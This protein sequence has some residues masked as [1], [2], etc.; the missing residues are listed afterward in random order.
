MR[1]NLVLGLTI[2]F[3]EA[4]IMS[5][6]SSNTPTFGDDD[7]FGTTL[8]VGGNGPNNYTK[9]QDAIDNASNGDTVFV[10]DDSS[11]YY[12]N[13]I[14]DKSINLTGENKD[15]TVIDGSKWTSV[16]YVSAERVNITGFTI[17]N[18]GITYPAAAVNIESDSNRVF[19]NIFM[20]NFCSIRLRH[21][22]GNVIMRNKINSN[23]GKGVTLEYSTDNLIMDNIILKN[24][25][26][27]F[28]FHSDNNIISRNHLG[29][30]GSQ[31]GGLMTV[32]D[33]PNNTIVGNIFLHSLQGLNLE[34][35]N[36]TVV[37]NNSF[38]NNGFTVYNS[39]N[40]IVFNNTVNDKPLLY[41]E[42]VSGTDIVVKEV[43]QVVL[44]NC[45]SIVIQNQMLCN[46]EVGIE[47]WK[48][49]NCIILNNTVSS[50]NWHGIWVCHSNNNTI[51]TTTI[52][53]NNGDG[54]RIENSC[55]NTLLGN[56]ILGNGYG[57]WLKNSYGNIL[58][59]NNISGNNDDG[60][61]VYNCS[62]TIITR[63][64]IGFNHY[65]GIWLCS[66]SD[67]NNILENNIIRN[68]NDGI[69]ISYDSNDNFLYHNNFIN[70]TLKNACDEGINTWD[71]GYPS[72]G[73]Y[74][75][76]FDEPEE[77]AYD[78]YHGPNQD[79][80]GSDGIVDKGY[81]A[82]GGLN[83]YH[84][85]GG[86]N[87]DTYPLIHP[88]GVIPHNRVVNL[89]TSELF[90][91][92]QDA[93]NDID[94]QDGHVLEAY[95]SL[96]IENVIVWKELTIRSKYQSPWNT[97]IVPADIDKPIV[98][99][100]ANNVTISGFEIRGINVT[101]VIPPPAGVN[102][103]IVSNCKINNC[104]IRFTKGGVIL[105]SSLGTP[106]KNHIISNCVISDNE[107]GIKISGSLYQPSGWNTIS[108]CSIFNNLYGI[109]IAF[110]TEDNITDS[111]IYLNRWCGIACF[112]Y[113]KSS[114]ANCKIY[115]NKY[116]GI[117]LYN[118]NSNTISNCTINSNMYGLTSY[119]STDNIVSNCII[120]GNGNGTAFY[121][122]SINNRIK[123]SVISSNANKGITG[124]WER[125]MLINC[126]ISL[127]KVGVWL[128]LA[129]N[130]TILNC[131]ICHNNIGVFVENSSNNTLQGNRVE[132]NWFGVYLSNSTLNQ[133]VS[134]SVFNNSYEIYPTAG[135]YLLSSTK[136]IVDGNDVS[137]NWAGI[138][139][140]C[141]VDYYQNNNT[142]ADNRIRHNFYGVL[143]GFP[144]GAYPTEVKD[145]VVIGDGD[146]VVDNYFFKNNEG[147]EISVSKG[148][149]ILSNIFVENEMGIGV[150]YCENGT[151]IVSNNTLISNDVGVSLFLSSN[152]LI[153]HN[154]FI[155]NKVQAR[156]EGN[157]VNRWNIS[158]PVGGNHWSDFDEPEEGAYDNYRGPNQTIPGSD[159]IVDKG[160][161]S[162]VP[163]GLNP[164]HIP[165]GE[166]KD[167]YPLIHP[168][169]DTE[170]PHV[171]VTKPEKAIYVN[172]K[173]IIPFFTTLVIG[174]ID[175]EVEASDD[176]T[177]INRVEFYIDDTLKST[178]AIPPYSW[179][180]SETA[181][182]R[183]TIE[184][185]AY[186]NAGN[187]AV[188]EIVVI[189]S[190]I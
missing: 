138:W 147:V 37:L 102:I 22:S 79:K 9:I 177:G 66:S 30:I 11:P 52:D 189:I 114:V 58:F 12:E 132:R 173:K 65:Y 129:K 47:L 140:D 120:S 145:D 161:I 83:P 156:D 171:K 149:F 118:A 29:Y 168:I 143:I 73:N 124:C 96:Y 155:R 142:I 94:T 18:S 87:K 127:N 158:Y 48:S 100:N 92:I 14:V 108:N 49:N 81:A 116:D 139:D 133:I 144:T 117:W 8:Y 170:S 174:F 181:F 176:Q 172:N 75:S 190:N 136:N 109:L 141:I 3:A 166:N 86:D 17:R 28:L 187:S 151:N 76:D 25:H 105:N 71:N 179:T 123:D 93:I 106:S 36:H 111:D 57:V 91:T 33:S 69:V 89:N 50:N 130:Y 53:S 90:S 115:S 99:I 162:D 77:G 64:V 110:S 103:W 4:S 78:D 20:D 152:N 39:Y 56:T 23:Y 7:G 98:H 5:N 38:F 131:S 35:S 63:N 128:Y 175:I 112:S 85:P 146:K 16:V 178:D 13:V 182:G 113:T 164:Y 95:P 45:D 70:N 159:G 188:D 122:G 6:I 10:Y 34:N 154:D 55:G 150:F 82:G 101:D 72:G 61:I 54:I 24:T 41:L 15:T 183:H 184:V 84:I 119:Y 157:G 97:T 2:L 19:N 26:G 121:I 31:Y 27:V 74:W 180:W 186:D 153:Y 165:G 185:I 148:N 104:Y 46:T 125:N 68:N 51:S 44:V 134:N 137:F 160:D 62:G 67:N 135:I 126:S 80:L 59:T 88:Y 107:W 163:N 167:M 43:G 60:I 32:R 1:K 40:N 42:G 169:N 21:S